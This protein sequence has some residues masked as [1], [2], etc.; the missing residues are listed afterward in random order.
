[1]NI[2]TFED[3]SVYQKAMILTESIYKATSDGT[4]SKDWGLRDQL[5]RAAVSII[6]NIAEV[7]SETAL[8]S[9]GA[10]F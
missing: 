8:L 7:M 9:I 2:K 10:S 3:L 4:F 6:S 5:R 1:M